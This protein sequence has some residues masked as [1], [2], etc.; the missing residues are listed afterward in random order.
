MQIFLN[1]QDIEQA[2]T[3]YVASLGI[4]LAVSSINFTGARGDAGFR[5]EIELQG[6]ARPTLA[7]APNVTLTAPT[8]ATPV[9]PSPAAGIAAVDAGLVAEQTQTT[10]TP[11]AGSEPVSEKQEEPAAEPTTTQAAN[12]LAKNK[13]AGSLFGGGAAASAAA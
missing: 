13:K 5:A 7:S 2:V 8:P 3:Q 9:D 6:L 4:G 1:Q 12:P 11:F 10:D